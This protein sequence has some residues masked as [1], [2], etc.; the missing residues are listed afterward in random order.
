MLVCDAQSGEVVQTLYSTPE[1]EARPYHFDRSEGGHSQNYSP[2]TRVNETSLQIPIDEPV[3]LQL[4][5]V[6]NGRN[7]HLQGLDC[8]T[9]DLGVV[10]VVTGPGPLAVTR[11]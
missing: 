9:C 3:E 6:N 5:F 8:C 10:V 7:M 2:V 1:F 4:L 11:H